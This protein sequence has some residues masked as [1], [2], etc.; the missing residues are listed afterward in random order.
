MNYCR[1]SA[2]P[3][4]RFVLDVHGEDRATWPASDALCAALQIINHLQDC[5]TDYRNLDRVY[6]PLDMLAAH[7]ARVEASE[8]RAPPRRNCAP[9]STIS[10]GRL[11]ALLRQERG[12]CRRRS[13]IARLSLEVVGDPT[14]GRNADAHLAR[15]RSVDRARASRQGWNAAPAD[16]ASLRR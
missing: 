6:L 7:G 15:A 1:Y 5:A 8:G 10:A 2:M 13:R 4:G 14:A 11:D 9:A 3:V 12:F 16:R